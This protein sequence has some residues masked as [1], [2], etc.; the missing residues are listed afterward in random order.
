MSSRAHAQSRHVNG[1]PLFDR[2]KGG[3][4]TIGESRADKA[5][6]SLSLELKRAE[7]Q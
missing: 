1:Q 3:L 7:V 4:P 6:W 5:T 2:R